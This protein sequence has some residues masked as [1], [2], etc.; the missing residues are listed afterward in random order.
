MTRWLFAWLWLCGCSGERAAPP[1]QVPDAGAAS[2][3]EVT[4]TWLSPSCPN[5]PYERVLTIS[6]GKFVAEDRVP[7]G[8]VKRAGTFE[9]LGPTLLLHPDAEPKPEEDPFPSTLTPGATT[10]EDDL[11]CTYARVP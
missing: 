7:A 1:A 6:A 2:R 8:A 10:I 9:R 3:V 5:R 4:G 11:D